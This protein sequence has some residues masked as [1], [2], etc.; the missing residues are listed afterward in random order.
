MASATSYRPGN[1]EIS[2]EIE[3]ITQQ[4]EQPVIA[5]PDARPIEELFAGIGPGPSGLFAS[6]RNNTRAADIDQVAAAVDQFIATR[7]NTR[8]ADVNQIASAINQYIATSNALPAS[9]SEIEPLIYDLSVYQP[10]RIN[11][12]GAWTDGST[13]GEFI[14]LSAVGDLDQTQAAG[15]VKLASD[16]ADAVD[17]LMVFRKAACSADSQSLV[18]GNIRQIAIVYKLEGQGTNCL[19]V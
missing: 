16:D 4:G 18:A 6:P 7:N 3:A 17:Y 14:D 12:A 5:P 2:F 13:A 8:L 19:E 9:W 15:G 10:D 1:T 11:G